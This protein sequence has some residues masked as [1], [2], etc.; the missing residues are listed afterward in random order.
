MTRIKLIG[1]QEEGNYFN[2]DDRL[3]FLR[4][5]ERMEPETIALDDSGIVANNATYNV[6]TYIRRGDVMVLDGYEAG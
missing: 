5:P 1:G 4:V 2:V 3:D 6:L